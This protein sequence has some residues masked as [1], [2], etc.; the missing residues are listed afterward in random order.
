MKTFHNTVVFRVLLPVVAPL[1]RLHGHLPPRTVVLL[2]EIAV[3]LLFGWLLI[4]GIGWLEVLVTPPGSD[5]DAAPVWVSLL[6]LAMTV[7]KLATTYWLVGYLTG[8]TLALH[9]LPGYYSLWVMLGLIAL[10]TIVLR[11]N[12]LF[13]ILSIL[14]WVIFCYWPH[15]KAL[16]R[17]K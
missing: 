8:H 13:T 6:Q 2:G 14:L 1:N 3:A 11:T 9:D 17:T 4:G 12:L 7:T 15:R 5:V 10:V 16:R